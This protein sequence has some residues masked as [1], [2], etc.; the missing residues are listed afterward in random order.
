[1]VLSAIRIPIQWCSPNLQHLNKDTKRTRIRTLPSFKQLLVTLF[2]LSSCL[3]VA[4]ALPGTSYALLP[5]ETPSLDTSR[6]DQYIHNVVETTIAP[7]RSSNSSTFALPALDPPS[8]DASLAT[9][10]YCFIADTDSFPFILDS[11]ANRFIANDP[12]LFS[13]LVKKSGAGVKG[14]GGQPI[15]LSGIG[16]IRLPLKSDN[17]EVDVLTIDDAVYISFQPCSA[18]APHTQA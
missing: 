5:G 14:I 7:F 16:T 3:S 15:P 11:G 12:T 17:G 10:P 6:Q 2:G 4:Y 18:T 8:P 1:M 13:T 9:Q